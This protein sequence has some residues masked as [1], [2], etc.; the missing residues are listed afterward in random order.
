M[1]WEDFTDAEL[2]SAIEDMQC[3][4]EK[5]EAIA[6]EYHSYLLRLLSIREDR[7]IAAVEAARADHEPEANSTS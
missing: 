3:E 1:S 7:L 6:Q 5:Q 2:E 4:V